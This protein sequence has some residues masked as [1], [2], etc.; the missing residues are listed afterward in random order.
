MKKILLNN[1]YISVLLIAISSFGTPANS[2]TT[3]KRN[4]ILSKDGLITCGKILFNHSSPDFVSIKTYSNQYFTFSASQIDSFVDS[5]G[6][7]YISKEVFYNGRQH[8]VFLETLVSGE[9][10]LFYL[11]LE[12][13]R[14]FLD[15]NGFIELTESDYRQVLVEKSGRCNKSWNKQIKPL[16]FEKKSLAYMVKAINN[17]RCVNVPLNHLSL[18]FGYSKSVLT[19]YP[20]V[21]NY[22]FYSPV[23]LSNQVPVFAIS[24]ETPLWNYN[25]LDIRYSAMFYQAKREYSASSVFGSMD[26]RINSNTLGF[27]VYPMLRLNSFRLRPYI[28]VGP[29]V[30]LNLFTKSYLIGDNTN[31]DYKF[32]E[33]FFNYFN[34]PD[35][36]FSFCVLIGSKFF[37]NSKRFISVEIKRSFISPISIYRLDNWVLSIAANL[38]D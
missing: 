30:Y 17:N 29:E 18:S 31:N 3:T 14:F 35:Y 2:Q 38:S 12:I 1:F 13:E 32:E 7:T 22:F 6:V 20:E 19:L 34:Y 21:F 28:A 16:K 11:N 27:G 37:Y 36:N 33:E 5:I 26:F 23:V 24:Y 25:M 15:K 4:C 8:S 9:N 10:T